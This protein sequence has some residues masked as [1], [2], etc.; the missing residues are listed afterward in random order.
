MRGEVLAIIK[1]LEERQKG[2]G[3][4]ADLLVNYSEIKPLIKYMERLEATLSYSLANVEGSRNLL[5][6]NR[7]TRNEM[8]ADITLER[9]GDTAHEIKKVLG[10]V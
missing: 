3:E 2:G 10:V 1:Q 8:I 6:Q 4:R 7:N 9:L 5:H